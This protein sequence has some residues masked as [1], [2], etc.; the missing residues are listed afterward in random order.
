MNTPMKHTLLALLLMALTA[1]P[2]AQA[3]TGTALVFTANTYGEHSPC[4]S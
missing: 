2:A 3:G 1:A 4:P